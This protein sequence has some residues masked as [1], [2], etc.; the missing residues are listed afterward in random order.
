MYFFSIQ[1]AIA[2][3]PVSKWTTPYGGKVISKKIPTV[4]CPEAYV[5]GTAPVVL[6]SNLAGLGQATLSAIDGN[7]STVNKVG[8]I[9]GGVYKAIPL[10]LIRGTPPKK[11]PKVGDWVLGQKSVIPNI[12]TCTTTLLGG[13]P[14]PVVKSEVYGVSQ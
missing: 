10:Y 1:Q 2:F 5:L 7:Q 12:S 6:S 4:V 3:T 13:V 14:F 11:Q 9:V 8:G